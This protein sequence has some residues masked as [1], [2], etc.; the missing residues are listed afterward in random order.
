MEQ[1]VETL[2]KKTITD[3]DVRLGNKSISDEDKKFVQFLKDEFVK[4][5]DNNEP[6]WQLV[7]ALTTSDENYAGDTFCWFLEE[8]EYYD[9]PDGS[10]DLFHQLRSECEILN[11][12]RY[13]QREFKDF[14]KE[15]EKGDSESPYFNFYYKYF[16]IFR[17]EID[18]NLGKQYVQV[19]Q[20]NKDNFRKVLGKYINTQ[21]SKASSMDKINLED[22]RWYLN[23]KQDYQEI[24]EERYY[25][26]YEKY[27]RSLLESTNH[28]GDR[29]VINWLTWA[30]RKTLEDGL[31]GVKRVANV[32][33]VEFEEGFEESV[34]SNYDHRVKTRDVKFYEG[35]VNG[36]LD[37]LLES[38]YIFLGGW[39]LFRSL[40][41]IEK[42]C[43][44]ESNSRET[45]LMPIVEGVLDKFAE[46]TQDEIKYAFDSVLDRVEKTE[47]G[48]LKEIGN[49]YNPN[50][51]KDLKTEISSLDLQGAS[52]VQALTVKAN[53]ADFNLVNAGMKAVHN[54]QNNEFH[55][56]FGDVVVEKVGD[57]ERKYL[58]FKSQLEE[59]VGTDLF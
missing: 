41:K 31:K 17:E 47:K 10:Y 50:F 18:S 59:I 57:I 28:H 12:K 21:I 53:A 2:V 8:N 42:I 39:E 4:V 58:G 33:G 20:D 16:G 19:L 6:S 32:A 54:Y 44:E 56:R 23:N 15:I 51:V 55:K 46:K 37:E 43:E 52:Y 27:F 34:L 29:E 13:E 9:V 30:K 5:R 26:N 24:V 22:L 25:G 48:V 45:I 35:K 14:K 7:N 36:A 40:E 49:E 11:D 38:N 3:L 1:A